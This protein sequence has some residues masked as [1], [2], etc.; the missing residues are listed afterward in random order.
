MIEE[1]FQYPTRLGRLKTRRSLFLSW[2]KTIVGADAYFR[3][4]RF[5][6]LPRWVDVG[7]DPYGSNERGIR[8]D[9]PM[10]APVRNEDGR[11]ILRR[12]VKKEATEA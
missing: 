6:S 12:F 1:A 7:I 9:T 4:R 2:A 8:I 11:Q 5:V 10:C 3:P